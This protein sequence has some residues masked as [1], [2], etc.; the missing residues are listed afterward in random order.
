MNLARRVYEITDSM[1]S[2]AKSGNVTAPDVQRFVDEIRHVIATEDAA[3]AFWHATARVPHAAMMAQ[4]VREAKAYRAA[5]PIV[6]PE[7]E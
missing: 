4:A 2:L 5:N 6:E 7:D 3:A 1:E